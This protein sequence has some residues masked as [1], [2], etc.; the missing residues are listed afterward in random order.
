[1]GDGQVGRWRVEGRV[2]ERF[3]AV[4]DAFEDNLAR[5][6]ELGGAVCIVVDGTV[7]CDLWGGH[8]DLARTRAWERDTLV[9]VFSVGKGL[10]AAAVA[11]LVGQGRLDY[12]RPLGRDWPEFRAEDK[13]GIT[14]REVLSHRAGLPAVRERL[15][16]DAMLDPRAMRAALAAQRPWWPPGTAHGY[17]VNTFGFLVGAVIERAV[18]T[19]IGEYLR[20]EVCGPIGADLHV[21]LG[22]MDLA[23]V[24]EFRW[25]AT[26]PQSAPEGLDEVGLMRFNAYFNPPGLSG[27][28]IVN[29]PAWRRCEHPSSNAHGTARGVAALYDA[30]ARCREARDA[31][32]DPAVLAIATAEASVG[33]DLVLDRPSRFSLGFQLSQPER[34]LGRSGRAFGHFGAGGSLG[35]CDPEDKVAFGYVTSD[36]GPRWQNPRNRGLCDALY[37][38]LG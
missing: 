22:E 29:S 25:E 31:L 33:D 2:D 7:V 3:S 28:G 6:G 27:A 10:V 38:A 20:S 5:H 13:A 1:V 17:H 14:L 15:A 24:A 8:R 30:L 35:F 23:R 32:V 4:R 19:S 11:R 34:P 21:G 26:A 16:D 12:D 36:M 37:D 18:G 9:D